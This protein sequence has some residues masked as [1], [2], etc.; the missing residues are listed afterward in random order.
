MKK[1]NY[2]IRGESELVLLKILDNFDNQKKLKN[3]SEDLD[4][5]DGISFIKEKNL[6]KIKNKIL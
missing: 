2:L 6:F 4:K 5:I 3:T 1:I